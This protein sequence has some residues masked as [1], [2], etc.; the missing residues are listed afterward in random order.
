MTRWLMLGCLTLCA[1]SIRA[2]EPI[3][4]I[5][6]AP[7]ANEPI[8]ARVRHADCEQLGSVRHEDGIFRIYMGGTVCS[9]PIEGAFPQDFTLGQLPAGQ[10]RVQVVEPRQDGIRPISDVVTFE[11]QP[12]PPAAEYFDD[13]RGLYD[14][15]GIWSNNELLPG[16][17]FFVEHATAS[18]RLYIVWNTYLADGTRD[19]RILLCGP[20]DYGDRDCDIHTSGPGRLTRV[21]TAELMSRS[22]WNYDDRMVLLL[23]SGD[24]TRVIPLFR[25][26]VDR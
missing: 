3:L 15:G 7:R 18:D 26:V 8:T 1:M 11:V 20:P 21:G 25:F 4:E 9:I 5:L 17:S 14:E 19:W 13:Y 10:Y 6:G 24:T 12:I 2:E 22:F 16:E 23:P